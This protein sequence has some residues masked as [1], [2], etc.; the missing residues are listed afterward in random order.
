MTTGIVYALL[1]AAIAVG[2]AGIGSAIGVA[3]AG[4][5][6]SGLLSKDPRN[7]VKILIMQVLPSTQCIYGFVVA[8]IIFN[9][10][11]MTSGEIIELSD[12]AGLSILFLSMPVGFVGLVSGIMQ[13]NTAVAGINLYG[14][15]PKMFVNCLV[16]IAMVEM[17]ALFGFLISLL[18][19]SFVDVTSVI[20]VV[21]TTVEAAA[22]LIA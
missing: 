19:I 5:A 6:A 2:V 8:F 3:R 4:Q 7:F 22:S 16:I 18:G 10:I 21:E 15:Q 11:G 12:S 13:G 17:F 14:K 20:E 9:T 1:G